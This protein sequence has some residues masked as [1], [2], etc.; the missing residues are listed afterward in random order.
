MM[1]LP[2]LEETIDV[3]LYLLLGTHPMTFTPLFSVDKGIHAHF[4][5]VGNTFWIDILY[6]IVIRGYFCGI[7]LLITLYFFAYNP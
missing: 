7:L 2:N 4:I 1:P 6:N 3:L 5:D